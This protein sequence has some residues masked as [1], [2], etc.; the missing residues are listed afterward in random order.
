MA[1]D[2]V[3]EKGRYQP[4]DFTSR[5]LFYGSCYKCFWSMCTSLGWVKM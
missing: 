3:K 1:E 4:Y 2:M 5:L